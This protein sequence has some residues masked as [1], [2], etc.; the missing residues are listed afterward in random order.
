MQ[1]PCFPLG[2]ERPHLPDDL[3]SGI[4]F[5]PSPDRPFEEPP[6]LRPVPKNP[7]YEIPDA[8][9][10]IIQLTPMEDRQ[11]IPPCDPSPEGTDR[12]PGMFGEGGIRPVV[13]QRARGGGRCTLGLPDPP[14]RLLIGDGGGGRLARANIRIMAWHR[15]LSPCGAYSGYLPGSPR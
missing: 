7:C 2:G 11:D 10:R 13:A 5:Q 8:P 3:C 9:D 15:E 4:V 14:G 12:P 1:G 6:I